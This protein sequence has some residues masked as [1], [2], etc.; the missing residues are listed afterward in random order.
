MRLFSGAGLDRGTGDAAFFHGALADSVSYNATVNGKTS[1][2]PESRDLGRGENRNSH[3]QDSSKRHCILLAVHR[4]VR[5]ADT[6]L[7]ARARIWVSILKSLP[8]LV[9][10][11][12]AARWRR[13][14]VDAGPHSLSTGDDATGSTSSDAR[15][16]R[17][18]RDLL[19]AF[20]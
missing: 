16:T 11:S 5:G 10:P 17:D 9:T 3:V 2:T 14:K 19:V 15:N 18:P 1:P 20:V 13:A 8:E 6:V 4:E 7:N 12:N